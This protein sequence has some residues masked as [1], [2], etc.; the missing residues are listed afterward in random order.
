MDRDEY[1]RTALENWQ[2]IAA[3]WERRREQIEKTTLPVTEWMVRALDPQPGDTVLELAAGPGDV[4]FA[5]AP[6][7]GENGR[8]VSSDFS[9][10]MLE[11][12]RRR[13]AELGLR[14]VEHRQIDAEDIPLEDDSVDG[15]LCR[16]GLML[17]PD[18]E[19]AVAEIRRVL[20]PGGRL[21]LAVWSTGLRNPW[22]TVAG[23]ILVE[24]GHAPP[25]DPDAPGPFVLAEPELLRGLLDDGGFGAV[26][27]E[28]VPLVMT[29]DDVED[30]V[31]V[32][33]ETSGM[34]A[35]IWAEVS[36]SER[37]VIKSRLAENF[38]PFAIEGGYAL[39]GV[40]VVAGAS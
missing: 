2:T 24:L 16:F 27:I 1:K 29:Y 4:G 13:A 26:H 10:E 9:S 35:R 30:F 12:A 5:A 38:A 36:D 22:V 32:S 39:P 40:A 7:L 18:P 11:V 6:L 8:L 19:A 15:V 21:A 34:L 25:P 23:R 28:E 3:G 37:E 31:A 17:M 14:N 20:R 33:T